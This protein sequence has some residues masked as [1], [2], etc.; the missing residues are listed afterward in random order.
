MK[1]KSTS[2]YMGHLCNI[3]NIYGMNSLILINWIKACFIL[4]F[5]LITLNFLSLP[6]FFTS[7]KHIINILFIRVLL[8]NYYFNCTMNKILKVLII[9]YNMI[10]VRVEKGVFSWKTYQMTHCLMHTLKQLN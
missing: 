3:C 8:Y 5:V 7:V 6:I 4:S 9:T 10:Y 1:I 2:I